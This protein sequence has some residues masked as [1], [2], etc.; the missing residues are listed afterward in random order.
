MRTDRQDTALAFHHHRAGFAQARANQS[1]TGLG[2]EF[3]YAANPFRTGPG[4]AK[5]ATGEDQPDRPITFRRELI[6]SGPEPPVGGQF[7]LLRLVELAEFLKPLLLGQAE[8][9]VEILIPVHRQPSRAARGAFG[10][11][12]PAWR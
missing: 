12:A 8:Q 4:L 10:A 7:L 9:K 11:C 5:S 6:L 3:R 2:I 1:Y